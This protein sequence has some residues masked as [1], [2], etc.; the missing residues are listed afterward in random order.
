MS[1]DVCIVGVGIHPFGRTDGLSGLEQGVFAVRQALADA[2]IDWPD[3]QFAYGSSDSAGNPDT[4]VDRLG[5]TGVQF[6]NVRNGCAAG[7]SALF[8][9]QMAIKSGEFDIGLAVGFDKHP[10]GAFNA[11]PSEYNLPD[12]YG[13]A[14]Y[15]ITTQFFAAKIM[16][17]MHEH[18]ISQTTLARVANKAF[19]NAVHAPHAWRREPVDMETILEAPLVSDPYTKYMFCSPAEGG[20]ALILASEKKARELGKPLVRLKAATMRTRPPKSFEVFAPSIDIGGGTATATRI[21]SAD[22]FR[23]AGIGP[24][25]IALA[26]LQDTECGAEIMHMAENGFCK[27]G[28]QEAWLAQGRTELGGALPVN[29]DGGCLACGEPIGASGLRQV[30]ENVV[31]LRGDGGGRQVQGNP[32]TAYSH[33]YGAPGVSAVT[34]LER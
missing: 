19:R 8:S 1:G 32:K 14:G 30:Y 15:M 11:L 2:G 13:D 20:V 6:I 18:G 23:M 34:I 5:L 22:A 27:D 29:T 12:W 4:M 7:G 17:Y 33:V 16:R 31:Q 25:D 21:A 3:V 26:Q 24:E 9:A 28:D 10:R